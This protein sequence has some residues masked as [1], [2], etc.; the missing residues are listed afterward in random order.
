MLIDT[1][2][3]INMMVKQTFDT[4]LHN[5]QLNL[6]NI[7]INDAHKADV[8][9]FINVGTSLIESKNCILLAQR[10]ESVYAAIGIHP[11]DATSSWLS[12]FKELAATIKDPKSKIVAL[13]ECGLDR[14]YPDYNLPRQI[15]V[16]RAHIECALEHNL[17][18]IVHTRDARDETLEVLHE[19]RNDPLSGSIHCFSEDLEF[20]QETIKLGF[21]LGIGGPLTYPK[22]NTLRNVFTTVDLNN[23]VLETDAPFLP[24]QDFRGK[25]NHPL[26]IATIAHYLAELRNVSFEEIAHATT[27]NAQRVFKLP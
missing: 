10:F 19:Y 11:N 27:T 24:P 7:I 15:D 22:N 2:S 13:G 17:P 26:H 20:A 18:I 3:H 23:I 25:Q 16:F 21:V 12:E 14:H 4:P 6:A 8:T 5:H 1:H 9:T